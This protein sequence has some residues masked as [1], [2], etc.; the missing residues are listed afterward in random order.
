MNRDRTL[1]IR[2]VREPGFR[3]FRCLFRVIWPR[4]GHITYQNDPGLDPPGSYYSN[5]RNREI[6]TPG[7]PCFPFCP[8]GFFYPIASLVQQIFIFQWKWNS[9]KLTAIIYFKNCRN[10]F[11][12]F[13]N[14]SIFNL[15]L[16]YAAKNVS[17]YLWKVKLFFWND[18]L[19]IILNRRNLEIRAHSI[20]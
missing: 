6:P 14:S 19:H 12:V 7:Q 16:F 20:F 8:I 3:G 15:P 1:P 10:C 4:I 11:N 9:H 18:E 17:C 5:C 2:V 13:S